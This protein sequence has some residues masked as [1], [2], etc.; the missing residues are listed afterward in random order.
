MI[1]DFTRSASNHIEFLARKVYALEDAYRA[2]G[3]MI[4]ELL[5]VTK[6][7]QYSEAQV[8]EFERLMI[9]LNLASKNIVRQVDASGV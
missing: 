8:A 4:S 7:H 1:R 2:Q 9:A 5:K 3:L 6:G